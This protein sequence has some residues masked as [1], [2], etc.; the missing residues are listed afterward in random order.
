MKRKVEKLIAKYSKHSLTPELIDL[1]EIPASHI[2]LD[3]KWSN[4]VKDGWY[5]FNLSTKIP[6]FWPKFIDEF[7]CIV[8]EF[9]QDFKIL[10]I[11]DKFGRCVI[12]LDN[13][14]TETEDL[15]WEISKILKY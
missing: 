15:T 8:R 6:A 4:Y 7:L 9:N 12:Y 10:Q 1:L 2:Y 11:K 13:V 5:G 3:Q 14:T